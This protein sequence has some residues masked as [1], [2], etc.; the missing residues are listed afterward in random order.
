MSNFVKIRLLFG[1]CLLA[2]SSFPVVSTVS[3]STALTRNQ[4]PA[5]QILRVGQLFSLTIGSQDELSGVTSLSIDQ[6]PADAVVLKNRSGTFTLMWVPQIEDIG[7]F[8]LDVFSQPDNELYGTLRL[9]VANAQQYE[10]LRQQALFKATAP[11]AIP[12]AQE[13]T[14]VENTSD[15]GSHETE[16]AATLEVVETEDVEA[17]VVE[18]E[19]VEAEVVEAEVVEAEVVE[20]E[21][22][23]AEVVEAEVVETE[24]VETEVVEAE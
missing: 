6:L 20:A 23:E 11:V 7:E 15:S 19:V 3:A 10:Q 2:C 13:N 4:S 17:E 16:M 5:E 12:A 9:Q 22:V 14:T 1:F 24:V 8:E 21:V 18:A